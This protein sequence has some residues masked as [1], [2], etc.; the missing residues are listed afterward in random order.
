MAKKDFYEQ[1]TE[2]LITPLIEENNFELVDIEYVKEGS[3]YYLRVYIDKEGGITVVD[4]E[5]ISRAFN[6]ILD[7]EDYIEDAYIFEVS[8]PG[9]MR[10]LKKDKDFQ[11]SIGKMIE[12]RLFR[13]MEKQ[14]EFEG[15]LQ[16]FDKDTI[17]IRIDDEKEI[18]F[19]RTDIALVRLA[20]E[21]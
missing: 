7:K 10:P 18:T 4:C 5:T 19:K 11:R 12:V 1:K 8:S 17:T 20:F 6:V 2:E 13:A 15:R 9:L 3:S 16:S 21:E 14:K